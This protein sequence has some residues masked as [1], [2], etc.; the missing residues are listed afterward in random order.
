MGYNVQKNNIFRIPKETKK[1]FIKIDA[2]KKKQDEKEEK[3]L[4]C[5]CCLINGSKKVTDTICY[6][7][8]L[9]HGIQMLD[10]E[11]EIYID[12]EEIESNIRCMLFALCIFEPEDRLL[13]VGNQGDYISDFNIIF[14]I[15]DEDT[16]KEIFHF[17]PENK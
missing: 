1:L 3:V 14:L 16:K 10:E 17:I 6:Q 2:N 9:G 15:Y 7:N 8:L 11:M 12:L 13:S 4:D 5:V